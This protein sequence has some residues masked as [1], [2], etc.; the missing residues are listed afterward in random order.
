M[1]SK[2]PRADTG[3]RSSHMALESIRGGLTD[4]PSSSPR[5]DSRVVVWRCAHETELK[6]FSR[7]PYKKQIRRS[8]YVC[9]RAARCTDDPEFVFRLHRLTQ[10][11]FDWKMAGCRFISFNTA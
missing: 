9:S 4:G 11:A 5:P 1:G 3:I 7:P 8:L 10:T 2:T 6:T